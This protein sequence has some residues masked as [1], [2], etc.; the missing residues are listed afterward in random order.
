[1]GFGKSFP[2]LVINRL[3]LQNGFT[4]SKC[5]DGSIDKYKARFLARVFSQ[6]EGI[7]YGK[8][9]APTARYNTI[10]SLVSLVATMGWNIHKM[11]IKIKFL[12]GT[13]DEEVHIEKL[14]GFEKNNKDTHVCKLKKALYGLK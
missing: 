6:K 8:T 1:M 13:I 5:Y 7:N 2:D 9:F 3:S 10:R 12:N 11:D 14:E 4:K